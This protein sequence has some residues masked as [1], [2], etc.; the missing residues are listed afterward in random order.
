ML[1]QRPASTLQATGHAAYCSELPRQVTHAPIGM[2]G[3]LTKSNLTHGYH[4]VAV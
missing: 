4:G 1:Q 2:T 3:R